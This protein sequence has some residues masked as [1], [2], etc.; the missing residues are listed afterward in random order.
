MHQEE[1]EVLIGVVVIWQ[2]INIVVFATSTKHDRVVVERFWV[3]RIHLGR[4]WQLVGVILSA[5]RLSISHSV[6]NLLI[7]QACRDC[8]RDVQRGNSTLTI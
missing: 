5:R 8:R 7:T 1:S 4:D 6:S 2:L 3:G